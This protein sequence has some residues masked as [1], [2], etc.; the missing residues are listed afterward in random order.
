ML[1]HHPCEPLQQG[2]L[3]RRVGQGQS[4]LPR[5]LVG[6]A[7]ALVFH[8]AARRDRLVA[9]AARHW[10]R[11][12]RRARRP[13]V[14]RRRSP[15]DRPD[16][17]GPPVRHAPPLNS[18]RVDAISD[19]VAWAC[20]WHGR[21]SGPA[22]VRA[23]RHSLHPF[24]R[25]AAAARVAGLLTVLLPATLATCRDQLVNPPPTASLIVTP[26][27]VIDSA[28]TGSTAQPTRTLAIS[29]NGQGAV[30]WAAQRA[31][32]AARPSFSI[33]SGTTPTALSLSFN[34]ASLSPG[35]Y[36]DTVVLAPTVVPGEVTRVPVEFR[37][38]PCTVKPISFDVLVDDSLRTPV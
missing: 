10:R 31:H 9:R 36:R 37:I 24:R 2:G 16:R 3:C 38:Q 13:P 15:R 11:A 7:E 26:G 8:D 14:R 35:V 32:G 5:T 6:G 22:T 30:I 4:Q 12:A 17:S 21:C 1:V 27:Q 34:P 25:S 33:T 20:A 23:Y 18:P 29:S 19:G 28:A